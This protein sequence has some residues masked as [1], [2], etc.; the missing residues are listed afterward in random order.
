MRTSY[1]PS[2]QSARNNE[3]QMQHVGYNAAVRESV[4]ILQ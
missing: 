1:L 2:Q 3:T 4:Y